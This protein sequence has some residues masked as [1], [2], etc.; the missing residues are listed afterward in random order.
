[1]DQKPDAA[2]EIESFRSQLF[3]TLTRKAQ[4]VRELKSVE[5]NE[6]ALTNLLA[7]TELGKQAAAQA[8]QKAADAAKASAKTPPV[9]L[10]PA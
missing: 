4:L 1:M 5:E 7:G 8:I 9:E 6:L 2:T 3:T 10:T